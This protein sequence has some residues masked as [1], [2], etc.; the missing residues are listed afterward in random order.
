MDVRLGGAVHLRI[1][2]QRKEQRA[3]TGI[4][5]FDGVE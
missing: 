5:P 4:Q 3:A 1:L 2:A